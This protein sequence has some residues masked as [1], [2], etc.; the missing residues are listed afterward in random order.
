MTNVTA[1][2]TWA[3]RKAVGDPHEDRVRSELEQRGWTAASYGQGILP[4]PIQ[5]ALKH[6]NSIMRWDP[7]LVAAQGSSI[8]L[9]DAKSSMRGDDAWTY[10]VSRKAI[11]AH[12]RMWTELDL[13]IYYV[14]HNLGVATPAQLMQWC[15]LSTLGEAGGYL[16]IPAG[17]PVP[18]DDVFGMPNAATVSALR[19]AA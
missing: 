5:R 12:L 15:R 3:E 9:V 1:L 18:F 17:L 4:E 6:T 11:R 10:H 2:S 19:R 14:F 8:C 13:P 7:D 16:S